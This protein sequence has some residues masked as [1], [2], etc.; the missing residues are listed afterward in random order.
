MK[1]YLRVMLTVAIAMLAVL[2]VASSDPLAHV[3]PA[4]VQLTG[5]TVG[6]SH[7]GYTFTATVSPLTATLPFT[8]SWE[9]TSQEQTVHTEAGVTDTVHLAWPLTRTVTITVTA[10]NV[11]GAVSDTHVILINPLSRLYLPLVLR[12]YSSG[13]IILSFTA[14]VTEADPG[15]SITLTWHSCGAISAT[16]Y[17]LLPSGQFGSFWDVAPT[18]SMGYDI[19]STTRNYERFSLFV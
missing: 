13:P 5:P 12:Q 2:E 4:G 17:H 19:P 6:E 7:T 18:G 1:R 10:I 3:P 11:G 15:E 16:L 9:A 14:N 8:Y